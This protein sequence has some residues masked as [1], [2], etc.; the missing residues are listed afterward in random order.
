VLFSDET[1]DIL[2]R[3]LKAHLDLEQSHDYLR[4]TLDH[5]MKDE[6]WTIAE[7]F[8][9]AD[10]ENKGWVS[11]LDVQVILSQN[12]NKNL[13]MGDLEYLFRMYDN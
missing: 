11:I 10:Q 1:I 7:I 9:A 3:L 2:Q 8:E 5:K 12:K 4:L 13:N 6:Q